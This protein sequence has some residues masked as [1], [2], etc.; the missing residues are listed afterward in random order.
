[1]SDTDISLF[2]QY[3]CLHDQLN[4]L[5]VFLSSTNFPDEGET[6]FVQ[7]CRSYTHRIVNA[8]LFARFKEPS[9]FS[10]YDAERA[11]VEFLLW[12]VGAL[13]SY[14]VHQVLRSLTTPTIQAMIDLNVGGCFGTALEMEMHWRKYKEDH[15][16]WKWSTQT[17]MRGVLV[18]RHF[19]PE[20]VIFQHKG[21][22]H[23]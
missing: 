14:D 19:Q 6:E 21:C 4:M 7:R 15:Y 3:A 18:I 17:V 5:M 13:N 2:P 22:H 1:M 11:I 10:V 20:P 8:T 16:D 9:G 23:G 12:R